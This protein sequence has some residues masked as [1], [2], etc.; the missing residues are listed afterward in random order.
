[1]YVTRFLHFFLI[2]LTKNE[3]GKIPE[4]AKIYQREKLES[5]TDKTIFSGRTENK[6]AQIPP[7]VVYNLT[8]R[9]RFLDGISAGLSHSE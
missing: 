6:M 2:K 1:M 5:Q 3:N 4:N 7:H 9:D 8:C